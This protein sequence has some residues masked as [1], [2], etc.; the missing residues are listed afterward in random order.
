MRA[1]VED[2]DSYT[3]IIDIG[4]SMCKLYVVKG[5][6]LVKIHRVK[7]GGEQITAQLAALKG[8]DFE[9]AELIKLNEASS[10]AHARDVKTAMRS[11]L[12]R[13]FQEFKR[14]IQQYSNTHNVEFKS[15]LLVGG[16]AQMDQIVEYVQE[17]LT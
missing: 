8:I 10:E 13:P 12:E 3:L 17:I 2:L 16:G 4:A 15:V 7:V 14:V 11:I 5:S 6:T 9:T 1:V